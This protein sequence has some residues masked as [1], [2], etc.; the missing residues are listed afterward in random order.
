MKLYCLQCKPCNE[1][2][3]VLGS[4]EQLYAR[5]IDMLRKKIRIGLVDME[6]IGKG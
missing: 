3:D 2:L 4:F 6:E 1:F 5:E